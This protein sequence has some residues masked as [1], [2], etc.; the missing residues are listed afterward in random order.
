MA[1]FDLTALGA[2]LDAL[3]YPAEVVG[4]DELRI[5]LPSGDEH[6]PA[7]PTAVRLVELDEDGTRMLT[8]SVEYPFLVPDDLQGDVVRA[9]HETTQYLVLGHFEVDDDGTVYLRYSTV[10]DAEAPPSP[11]VLATVVGLLD[12][13]Q[14]HFGDYLELICAGEVDIDS[15]PELVARGEASD[16][17]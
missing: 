1:T 11:R 12:H 8:F 3:G 7:R 13:Q 17:D 16:I 10:V 5:E 15:Y 2:A 14:Q 6:E 9:A 4:G